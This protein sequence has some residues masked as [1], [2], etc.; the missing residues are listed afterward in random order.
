MH[1]LKNIKKGKYIDNFWR[2]LTNDVNNL[3]QSVVIIDGV[4]S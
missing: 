3:L 4:S 1:G 2:D